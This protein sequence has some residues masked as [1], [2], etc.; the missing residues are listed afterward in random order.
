MMR[1]LMIDGDRALAQ[2]VAMACFAEGVAVR[3]A[4][5]LCEGVRFMVDGSVS[6]VLIDAGL[7]RLSGADQIRL[8]ETVAPGVPVVVVV[9][10]DASVDERVK[11]QVQGFQVV[12]KPFEVRDV[13]AKVE[14]PG[15][16]PRARPGAAAEVEKLCGSEVENL[17]G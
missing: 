8:F 2:S 13:L 5:T 9:P 1:V 10:D 12:S 11:F 7:M 3:L 15:R 17:C 14:R 6:V 16:S 4:E